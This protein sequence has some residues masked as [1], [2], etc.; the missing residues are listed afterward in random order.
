MK[1]ILILLFLIFNFTAFSQFDPYR[2]SDEGN[3]YLRNGKVY[4]QKTF[5]CAVDFAAL[6]KKLKSYNS[7]NG[8]FQI[9]KTTDETMNGVLVN[10]NLNWNYKE[11][12]SRKIAD[13]LKNP[14]NAT[15]E[16][17]K[18]GNAYQVVVNNIWFMDVKK[19][20]NK[21]HG[22][23][24]SIVTGKGGVV[25]TK[26]KKTLEALDMI[27]ENFQWIFQMEGSTKD[28]RF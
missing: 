24:E 16:V 23:L 14:V 8:G 4:F 6:E 13:F 28:T 9:K 21:S 1:N 26:D 5:N 17:T 2:D 25:F 7:P 10:Y 22:T 27:D 15:Y 12:K 18:N 20:S 19:P 11:M 3:F